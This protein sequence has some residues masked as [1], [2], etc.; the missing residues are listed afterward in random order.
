MTTD[1]SELSIQPL[2]LL[3][4]ALVLP[5]ERAAAIWAQVADAVVRHGFAVTVRELGI[6]ELTTR[7]GVPSARLPKTGSFDG[8]EIAVSPELTLSEK[9][10]TLLHLFGH[11]V[12]CCSSSEA[13]IVDDFF[14]TPRGSD[15]KLRVLANYEF[16][17]SQFGLWLLHDL[18]VRDLDEWFATFVHTDHRMVAETYLHGHAPPISECLVTDGPRIE[19]APVPADLTP[20]LISRVSAAY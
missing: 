14:R 20:Q 1:P 16:R 4:P 11:S 12:Q 6:V 17:A 10:F 8:L 5:D 2:G 19:P 15:D 18:G 9:I 13:G 3:P 7:D